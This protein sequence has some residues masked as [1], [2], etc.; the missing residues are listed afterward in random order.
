[1][2]ENTETTIDIKGAVDFLP[3]KVTKTRKNVLSQFAI[4]FD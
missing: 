1:M 4:K 2:P 3:I